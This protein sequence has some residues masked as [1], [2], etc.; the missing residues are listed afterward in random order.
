MG[1]LNSSVA[2]A[3]LNY[4]G[5]GTGSSLTRHHAGYTDRKIRWYQGVD[6]LL[7]LTVSGDDR[8]PFSLL[9]KEI[10]FTLWDSYTGTTIF[11]RRAIPTTAEN[12]EARLTIFARDLMTSPPGIYTLSATVVDGRGLETAL[13]WDRA[14]KAG[15]DIEICEAI[16]PFSR[17]TFEITEWPVDLTQSVTDEFA[18]SSTEGPSYY[19]KDTSLF[20]TAVYAS[21]FSGTVKVQGTLDENIT[22][23][24]MWADLVP[25]DATSALI[26]YAGYT[27]IDPFNYY[28]GVRW[29][30]TVITTD[31]TNA[32]T[33]DKI[34]I[35]V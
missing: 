5:A 22:G 18:S 12:G 25:Q 28:G 8:R 2:K 20:S 32:G 17:S 21:N 9:H 15:W 31:V 23:N 35:R 1:T 27:G 6:N 34:L 11:K 29:L 14:Y 13:T 7:D 3:N 19:R 26:T 4:A 16:I 24:T 33:L 30:R 10:M